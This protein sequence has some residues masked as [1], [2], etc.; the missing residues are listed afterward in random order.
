MECSPL[1]VSRLKAWYI[2]HLST[3]HTD[4]SLRYVRL[5]LVKGEKVTRTDE[6]LEEITRLTLQGQADELL[7]RTEPLD[8]LKDIFHYK[9]NPCPRL[10]LIMGAPCEY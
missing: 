3:D 1:D 5:A 6:N 7:L 4:W 9:D 8:D 2:K 10:I